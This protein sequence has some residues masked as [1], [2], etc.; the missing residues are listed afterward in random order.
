MKPKILFVYSMEPDLV[1]F[2]KDGLWAALQI[3]ESTFDVEYSNIHSSKPFPHTFSYPHEKGIKFILG[4]GAFGGPVDIALTKNLITYDG[5]SI[6]MGL[7]I[8]GNAVPPIGSEKYDVLFYETN[9]YKEEIRH[10]LNIV[11]AFGINSNIYKPDDFSRYAESYP[12]WN[13]LTVGA[14]ASWK[15]QNLLCKKPG[16]KMAIGQIQKS[17]LAES[18][19]I[20]GDLLLDN[21]AISDMVH[22]EV[23]VK[24]Y[25][26]A[27]KVYIPANLNGG[28]ERAVLEARAC[29]RS[30]E[31]EDD[32]PKLQELLTSP[33]WEEKYYANQLKEGILKC[34]N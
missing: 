19:D 6:K 33:I 13:Y 30:V 29:E 7:C 18:I 4:W 5:R 17:N 14:F 12:I 10:H 9:W 25:Y 20:I 15:R 23:L 11:H 28:G 2:W 27:E 3:L 31:V 24:Y 34:L 8:G 16:R 21:V 26:M 1:P 22:P 32:N